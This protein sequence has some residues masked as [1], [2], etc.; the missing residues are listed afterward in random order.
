[1]E[2]ERL[3]ICS[4]MLLIL[5]GIWDEPMQERV[6]FII[7]VEGCINNV[8]FLIIFKYTFIYNIVAQQYEHDE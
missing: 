2:F 1:M 6:Y 7:D 8:N 3:L 4:F 5:G